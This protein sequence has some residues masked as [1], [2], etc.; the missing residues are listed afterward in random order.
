MIYGAQTEV[1]NHYV[2]SGQTVA[3]PAADDEEGE[4]TFDAVKY[5]E[6]KETKKRGRKRK[7]TSTGLTPSNSFYIYIY[8]YIYISQI[9]ESPNSCFIEVLCL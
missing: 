6:E 3:V 4:G 2:Y 8:V 9:G 7:Q 1:L 5:H